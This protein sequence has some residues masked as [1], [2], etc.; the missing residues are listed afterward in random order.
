MEPTNI[1]SVVFKKSLKKGDAFAFQLLSELYC[2]RLLHVSSSYLTNKEDAKDIVQDVFVKLWNKKSQLNI[3]TNL[4]SYLY[5]MT[6][7][8][9]IDYLRKKENRITESLNLEFRENNIHLS[10]LQDDASS[11][12][13]EKELEKEIQHAISLLPEKCKKVFIKSRIQGLKHKEISDEMDISVKTI[14]NH[15]NK[16]LKHMRLHLRE[17]IALF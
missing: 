15:M 7:N 10:S 12:V 8:T 6:K 5:Q 11:E 17:F 14:E 1:N 16:A 2:S 13:I 4:N 3:H 9:C